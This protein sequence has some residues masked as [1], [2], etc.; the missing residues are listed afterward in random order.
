MRTRQLSIFA[1]EQEL[2]DF[3]FVKEQLER[4]TDSDTIRAMIK[5]CKKFLLRNVS[6]ENTHKKTEA[7]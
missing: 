4:K 3:E 1:D 6:I 5:L 2:K 7:V